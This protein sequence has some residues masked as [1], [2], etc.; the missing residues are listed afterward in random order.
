[1]AAQSA[2]QG[3]AAASLLCL[4]VASLACTGL[5]AALVLSSS[6]WYPTYAHGSATTALA[7]QQL[8]GIVMWGFANVV[9]VIAAAVLF[10]TWLLGLDRH[11]PARL[12]TEPSR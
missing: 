6:P 10:G 4:F 7:D 11:N 3:R 9:L 1:M 12:R 2:A 8:A 5:G